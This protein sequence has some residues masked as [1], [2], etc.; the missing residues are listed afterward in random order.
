MIWPVHIGD[1]KIYAR[2]LRQRTANAVIRQKMGLKECFSHGGRCCGRAHS[3]FRIPL[4]E[5]V[6]RRR[7]G[8]VRKD[9]DEEPQKDCGGEEEN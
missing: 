9:E 8:G 2:S 7:G 1:V 6:E 5:K 4:R 3:I